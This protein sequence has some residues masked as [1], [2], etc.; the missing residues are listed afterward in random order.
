MT[1]HLVENTHEEGAPILLLTL[2]HMFHGSSKPPQTSLQAK[3]V[4]WRTLRA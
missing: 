4:V 1:H 2:S 3:N